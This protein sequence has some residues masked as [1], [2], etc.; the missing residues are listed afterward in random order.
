MVSSAFLRAFV[1]ERIAVGKGRNNNQI[2]K[3][4]AETAKH[5]T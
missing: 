4:P 1:Q 5:S 3:T 2:K